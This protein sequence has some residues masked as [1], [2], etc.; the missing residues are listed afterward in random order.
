MLIAQLCLTLCDP[1]DCSLPG[2]S[3]HGI[4]QAKILEW[5]AI[6]FSRRSSWSRDWTHVSHIAVR[7][8]HLSTREAVSIPYTVFIWLP[9]WLSGKEYICQCRRH[10]RHLFCPWVG[11]I[12]W[13][14]EWLPT[15][16]FWSGVFHRQR[17][18]MGY[19]PWDLV[20]LDMTEHICTCQV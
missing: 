14:R 16:V 19:N 1:M 18:L 13:R 6:S 12:P 20:Q 2:S 5:L 10:K 3:V 11:K 4:L 17:S 9:R 8:Y 7:V 15:L